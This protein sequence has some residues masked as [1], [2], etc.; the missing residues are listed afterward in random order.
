[1]ASSGPHRLSSAACY[2]GVVLATT[3]QV[4]NDHY[5]S[6]WIVIF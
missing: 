2:D 6:E 4:F 5:S 1:M 3:V